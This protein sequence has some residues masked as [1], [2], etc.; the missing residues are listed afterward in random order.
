MEWLTLDRRRRSGLFTLK[1]AAGIGIPRRDVDLMVHRGEV[2]RVTPG[3]FI[4]G[5]R[6]QSMTPERQHVLRAQAAMLRL[7][8]PT[9][10]SH[11]AAA[12]LH[13]IP[14][15]WPAGSD[16]SGR[17]VHLTRRGDGPT[18]STTAQ[19]IHE[20]YGDGQQG[21][22]IDGIPAVSPLLATFGVTEIDGFVAGVVALDAALHHQ[23]TST[24][25]ARDGLNRLRRRPHTA[26]IRRVIDA[27]DGASESPLESQAR[28]VLAALGYR[29]R[30][31]VRL[32]TPS[33]AFV[34]RVD[35][36]LDALGVVIEVDGR[37]KYRSDEGLGSVEALLSEKRRESAIR[38]LGY[39]VVR[40]D[41][42]MISDPPLVDEHV[43][44]AARRS[45]A[46][47]RVRE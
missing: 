41:H 27:A 21:G 24:V 16:V 47:R 31:Q 37:G 4:L 2:A 19:T 9:V 7:R 8:T 46:R 28:L 18:R 3:A 20:R 38:D 40:L 35:G 34:A 10:V 15:L 14:L 29:M 17:R 36:L 44:A 6:W 1:D 32:E 13:G 12:A 5:D 23:Q 25:Q 26:T 33:G 43:K 30:P 42:S 22:D 45:H 39:G 11:C